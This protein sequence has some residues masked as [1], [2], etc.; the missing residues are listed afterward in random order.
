MG[1]IC[2]TLPDSIE[3]KITT[4]ADAQHVTKSDWIHAA[5][6]QYL[7][8]RDQD[9]ERIREEWQGLRILNATLEERVKNQAGLIDEM[10]S[11]ASHAEGM[12]EERVKTYT[13][14]IDELRARAVHAEGLVQSLMAERMIPERTGK[15]WWQFWK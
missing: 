3:E 6:V 14:L 2:I 5:I 12:M 15:P 11:R 1:R 13:G 9:C 7:R 4:E 8:T 10:K